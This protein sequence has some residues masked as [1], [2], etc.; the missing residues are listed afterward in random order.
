MQSINVFGAVQ[1]ICVTSLFRAEG[2]L[3]LINTQLPIHYVFAD[4]GGPPSVFPKAWATYACW[5][6]NGIESC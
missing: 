3:L 2:L 6:G 5:F 4:F 1:S